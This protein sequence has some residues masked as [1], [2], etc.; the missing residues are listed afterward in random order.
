MKKE[1][2]K[3]REMGGG[4]MWNKRVCC[5]VPCERMRNVTERTSLSMS[6]I[7]VEDHNILLAGP[8]NKGHLMMFLVFFF[9]KQ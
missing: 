9:P 8:M 7:V 4:G 1:K 5:D 3:E 2:K 6:R